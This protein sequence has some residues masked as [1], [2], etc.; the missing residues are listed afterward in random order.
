MLRLGMKYLWCEGRLLRG[1]P[2]REIP[3][4]Y[5]FGAFPPPTREKRPAVLLPPLPSGLREPGEALR[6]LLRHALPLEA[7]F[8]LQGASLQRFFGSVPRRFS[9]HFDRLCR[10][11]ERWELPW[12]R[13]K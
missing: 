13:P 9:F 12:K 4:E 6:R 8:S 5:E 10:L 11:G 1:R 3:F 2:V 7:L